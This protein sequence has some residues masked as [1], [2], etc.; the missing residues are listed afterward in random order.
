MTYHSHG[1]IPLT[2]PEPHGVP[3]VDPATGHAGAV[4]V[5][6]QQDHAFVVWSETAGWLPK[7][8]YTADLPGR[9]LLGFGVVVHNGTVKALVTSSVA[10]QTTQDVEA[11]FIELCPASSL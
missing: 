5:D 6:V 9:W 1:V 7:Q 11:G 10:G 8:D 3:V 4:Y 2:Q